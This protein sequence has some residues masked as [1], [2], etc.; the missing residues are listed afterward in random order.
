MKKTDVSFLFITAALISLLAG[1]L[2]GVIGGFQYILPEFLKE[3]LSFNKTRPIHV[4]LVITWIFTGAIG[5]IYYYLPKMFN[6]KLYSIVLAQLHFAIFILTGIAILICYFM[7]YFGG[8]EYL[9][10][11]PLLA[12][13]ML[14]TWVLFMINFFMTINK[15][16]SKWPVYLWMWSTGVVFFL[17]TFGEAY[18][19]TFPFFRDN[20]VRDVTVQWKAM[21]SMVGSWNMLVYGTGFYIMEQISGNKKVSTSG[22]TFFFYFLGLTNLMF[23]WGHHTYIVPAAPWIK[24][25]AYI[26][27]MTELLILGNIIWNWQKSISEAK[28]NS[29]L[30]SYWFLSAAEAWIFLN[31]ILAIIISIPSI[32][33]YTHGT[34]I[35]VAHAMGATIGIN[36][37]ILFASLFFIA[38]QNSFLINDSRV[39]LGFWITNI[40]LLFFWLSLIGSGIV[41]GMEKEN[42]MVFQQMMQKL[43][44][45]FHAFTGAGSGILV[46]ILIISYPLFKNILKNNFSTETMLLKK[47]NL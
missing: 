20:M 36:T 3:H 7:G 30:I 27:S 15:K 4:T 43:S 38:R 13:P 29:H 34:H 23:N 25:V 5:G 18:L 39:K 45:W 21:G 11:P 9:E 12:L 8:R 1:L 46:G 22:I 17:I 31:L 6:K 19:W 2:F 42:G 28:K 33:Y 24:N 41:K 47:S 37:M 26:I 44:P 40:S 10:F 35:T 16:V 32:N 14:L